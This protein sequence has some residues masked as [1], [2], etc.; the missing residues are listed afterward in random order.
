M[1]I[2][3]ENSGSQPLTVFAKSLIIDVPLGSNCAFDLEA[4][5]R[6]LLDNLKAND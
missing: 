5:M 6:N 4:Q 3:C 1:D 2:F